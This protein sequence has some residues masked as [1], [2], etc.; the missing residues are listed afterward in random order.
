MKKHKGGHFMGKM[1]G[2][3]LPWKGG[4]KCL[5]KS[6]RGPGD[7]MGIREQRENG[8]LVQIQLDTGKR[9]SGISA[10]AEI[11]E[12]YARL[13]APGTLQ[14]VTA[15]EIEETNIFGTDEDR[16]RT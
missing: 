15:R 13:D 8:A 7:P 1:K 3:R 10:Y 9:K 2:V 12:P 5:I 14:H 6:K 16:S 4:A 11:S